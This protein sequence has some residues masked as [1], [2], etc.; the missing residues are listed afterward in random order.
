[1][2]LSYDT[3]NMTIVTSPSGSKWNKDHLTELNIKTRLDKT[4]HQLMDEDGK[5]LNYTLWLSKLTDKGFKFDCDILSREF[6]DF[7]ENSI[8]YDHMYMRCPH[9]FLEVAAGNNGALLT[10]LAA[11]TMPRQPVSADAGVVQRYPRKVKPTLKKQQM[12]AASPPE[13]PVRSPPV[14]AQQTPRQESAERAKPEIAANMLGILFSTSA[15]N[16]ARRK[17]LTGERTSMSREPC[18]EWKEFPISIDVTYCEPGNDRVIFK[19]TVINDGSLVKMHLVRV[20]RE[21]KW[22]RADNIVYSSLVVTNSLPMQERRMLM[23]AV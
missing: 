13:T 22:V 9:Y 4:M 11:V 5:R 18:L 2:A 3:P 21:E 17:R 23:I 20:G 14:M 16:S 1:M 10:S 12:D 8:G 19:S 6:Q 7:L 15:V